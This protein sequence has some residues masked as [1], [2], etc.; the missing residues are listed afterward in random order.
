MP[1]PEFFTACGAARHEGQDTHCHQERVQPSAPGTRVEGEV[2]GDATRR[3]QVTGLTSINKVAL[4]S[5]SG[6]GMV[7]VPGIA[8][9]LFTCLARHRINIIFISQ[10]SSEQS[11]SLAISPAQAAGARSVLEEEFHSE[12]AARQIDSIAVRRNLCMIA[13]V[14]NNMSGH[15]GV[16]AKTV[17]NT[18]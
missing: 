9:R 16:S 14:G 11:I 2:K 15:P 7:G 10:A 8:S 17:R 12:I 4:L 6:S 3:R 18:W 1:E 13:V 5:L